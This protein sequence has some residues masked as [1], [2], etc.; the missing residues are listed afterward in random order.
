ML[1]TQSVALLPCICAMEA[2]ASANR[3]SAVETLV[4][5]PPPEVGPGCDFK[6]FPFPEKMDFSSLLIKPPKLS[7]LP[8]LDEYDTGDRPE[9]FERAKIGGK[10]SNGEM[11]E[12]NVLKNPV[13]WILS[14]LIW[15]DFYLFCL[16]IKDVQ[17]FFF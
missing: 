13:I 12:L 7:S 17:R 8:E 5:G 11:I 14:F 2:K 3:F 9:I 16:M 4:E 15:M 10:M 1:L 6:T